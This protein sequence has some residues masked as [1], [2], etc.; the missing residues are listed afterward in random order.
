MNR[1]ISFVCCL[2]FAFNVCAKNYTAV[3]IDKARNQPMAY[4]NVGIIGHNIGTV[5]GENGTFILEVPDSLNP[6]SIVMVSMIG[7]T[8]FRTSLRELAGYK[9]IS[10]NR[11]DNTLKEVVVQS[12]VFNRR[13]L[14]NT[15]R[16][17]SVQVGFTRDSATAEQQLGYELGTLMKI[18]KKPTLIDSVFFNFSR[19]TDDS[20]FFRLNIYE[21]VKDSF[22][23]ILPKPYYLSFSKEEAL[24]GVKVNLRELELM[25]HNNFVVSLELIREMGDRSSLFFSASFLSSKTYF[26]ATSQGDWMKLPMNIGI[27]ISAKVRD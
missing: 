10:L 6:G 13:L 14:G 24:K 26:R 27:G 21:V 4:A 19:C 11:A 5:T 2:C 22:I 17:M 3:V 12:K 25:V 18:R 8:S 23:N 15:T 7:Y 16:S 1:Y 9:E 20:L